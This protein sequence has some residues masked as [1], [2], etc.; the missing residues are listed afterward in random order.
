[1]S[2]QYTP[3][4]SVQ[5]AA[6]LTPLSIDIIAASQ[7]PNMPNMPPQLPAGQQHPMHAGQ[8]DKE[9]LV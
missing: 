4:A 5:H 8:K 6:R 2:C 9:H 7:I 3:L 1:M